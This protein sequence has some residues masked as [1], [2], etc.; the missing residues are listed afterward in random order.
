M[1]LRSGVILVLAL[2][3]SLSVGGSTHVRAQGLLP[4]DRDVT[5][6]TLDN[7]LRYYV[8]ANQRP[9]NR[10]DLRLVVNAGS[11]LEDDGQEGLAHLL[12]HMAF[13]GTE[14]FP[15]QELVDYLEGIGMRFGPDI[16]AY[17]TFDETVYTLTVPSDS[18]DALE[19][20]FLILS[21]WAQNISLDGTEIDQERQ[22][23]IEE[24]RLG[25][26][27]SMRML[28]QQLPVLFKGARYAERLPIG[29]KDVLETFGHPV[30]K[31]F[32]L[33]WYRPD[34]M[35]VVAVGDFDP[36][37]IEDLIVKYFAGIPGTT[38][39]RPRPRPRYEVPGHDETLIT[40]ATDAEATISR[41]SVYSKQPSRVQRTVLAY[42]KGIVENLYS[43]MLND[44]LD[45][46]SQL[47]N[48][49]FLGASSGQGRFVRTSEVYFLGAGVADGGVSAGLEALLTEAE[50]VRRYGFTPSELDR[51]KRNIQRAVEQAFAEREK[52]ESN[53]YAAGYVQH[54][55]EEEPIPGIEYEYRAVDSLLPGIRLAEV[56][57]LAEEWITD[58]N[59]VIAV[60]APEKAGARV[61]EDEELRS[62]LQAVATKI[63]EPYED[64]VGDAPLLA[65]VPRPGRVVTDEFIDE[66]GVTVWELSNGVRV[67]LKPTDFKDDEILVSAS[68][69]GGTSLA[70]DGDYVPAMTA[71]SVIW[72]GGVGDLSRIELDKK[73]A[74][75][76]VSV[77]P[78][79]TSLYEGFSG[80]SSVSDLETFF[81]LLYL[82][83][84]APRR[85]SSAFSTYQARAKGVLENRGASPE[86]A[87]RDTLRVTL[88]QHHFR[89]RPPTSALYDEMDLDRSYDFYRDRF[90][91]I[92]DFTFTLV[93]SFDV[94]TLRPLVLTYIGSL[95]SQGREETWREI[96]ID[97]PPGVVERVVRRGVEPKSLTE[98]VFTGSVHD[99]RWNRYLLGSLANVLEIRL[100]ELLREELGGTYGVRVS[101]SI[102]RYPD[103]EYTFRVSFGSA[104]DRADELVGVVFQ[105]VDSLRLVGP[106]LEYVKK[107]QEAQRRAH[108]T[109]LKENRYWLREL[110]RAARF[111][112]DPREIV[113]RDDLVDILDVAA[114]REAAERFLRTEHYVRVSLKPETAQ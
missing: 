108:E 55:L 73:L 66:V 62:I 47:P 40:T 72:F 97:P 68:S 69:P 16:N 50:R 79:V 85:D 88:A 35:A 58:R 30:L 99:T 53:A 7:G 76:A 4:V 110:Q 34:L 81:Q 41:V 23:V 93:G 71:A 37:Q 26:G 20:A 70:S 8:R 91:D 102:S 105:Q 10:A 104:P 33:D 90:G 61:P 87:F 75:K 101:G 113:H 45:E 6:D 32:Y 39:V 65:T 95:P 22:V 67:V 83:V 3:V 9:E 56:N 54:F 57:R 77:A 78:Y 46:I 2:P 42:R 52:T 14:R 12:E 19:R 51:A 100:R 36:Q 25:R 31:R 94:E 48:A 89:A 86:A 5:I 112:E 60:N 111:G 114:V 63:I 44:R 109:N 17:T 21:E 1:R 49:P 24:W 96:D 107:T 84:T 74:G 43:I 106:T 64:K 80:N 27:A 18:A 29:R 28:N 59:R 103:E 38:E 11:V 13:N 15:R 98:I 92:G 82:Y